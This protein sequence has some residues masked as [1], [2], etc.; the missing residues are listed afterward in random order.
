MLRRRLFLYLAPLRII[1]YPPFQL[2][3]R[4]LYTLPVPDNDINI[5]AALESNLHPPLVFILV[6]FVGN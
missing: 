3:R 5:Y 1:L 2:L 4:P 6:F